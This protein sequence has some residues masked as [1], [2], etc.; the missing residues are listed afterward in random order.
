MSERYTI[1]PDARGFT[2]LDLEL[3]GPATLASL[4]QTGLSR[5]DAE[6]TADLLN[7]QDAALKAARAA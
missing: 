6:H 1:R 5:A 2:V 7:R 4:P 3:A